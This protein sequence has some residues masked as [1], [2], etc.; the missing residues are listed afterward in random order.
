MKTLLTIRS[1]EI[2]NSIAARGGSFR[3]SCEYEEKCRLPGMGYFLSVSLKTSEGMELTVQNKFSDDPNEVLED[4]WRQFQTVLSTSAGKKFNLQNV[5]EYTPNT[6]DT[7][8]DRDG[9]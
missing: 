8:T 9:I 3:L 4:I 1:L 5:L 2:L 6:P 7:F